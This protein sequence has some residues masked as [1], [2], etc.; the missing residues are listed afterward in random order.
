MRAV[1]VTGGFDPIHSGHIAYFKAAKELGTILYVGVNSDEWLTRKKGRPFM[2]VEERMAIIKEIGCVGHVFTFNDD[3]DT[4]IKAIEY[5][6]D[7]TPKT[8]SIVFANGGDRTKENIPEMVF[9]DVSFAFSVGGADKKNSS[10][11]ILSEWDKPTTK[12]LWGTYK[13]L[14]QNGHWK[15][16]E[17][18]IDVGKSLS[19][20][21]HFIR[22]EHWHIVSGNLKMDL[23]FTNGY[24]TSNIY[25]TGDSIDIPVRCWH[26]ATNV[27]DDPV[28]VIE[29]WMGDTLS[30][31]DIER[32]YQ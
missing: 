22:S 3:D 7:V 15:V 28:K 26:H 12:R 8:A 18:S 29:V 4:A 32:R 9:D 25:K 19:D 20:Q 1:I 10:S 31:D 14:D 24:A 6:K 5:V 2:S 17:L 13:D 16:K 23:E 30:E 11:W 27:G 21:R